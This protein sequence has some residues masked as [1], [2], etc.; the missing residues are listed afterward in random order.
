MV[1]RTRSSREVYANHWIRVV[2]DQVVRPDGSEGIYGVLEVRQPAVFVVA[3]DDSERVVLVHVERH[4]TGASWEVPAGGSDGEDLR[5]AAERELLEETGMTATRWQHLGGQWG[6]NGVARSRIEVFLAR[7]LT[8]TGGASDASE[9][10]GAVEA[11]TW[12]EVKTMLRDGRLDDNESAGALLL[13]A[14]E[15]GWA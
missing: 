9:G 13:A 4:T 12:S 1:W 2:E 8:D 15:L 5:V 11:F 6:L 10:I 3:V 7:D 14:I